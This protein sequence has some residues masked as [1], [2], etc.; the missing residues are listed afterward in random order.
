MRARYKI[1]VIFLTV[2]VFG[3]AMQARAN[4]G[5]SKQTSTAN[6]K[7]DLDPESFM[8]TWRMDDVDVAYPMYEVIVKNKH[9]LRKHPGFF[10]LSLHKGFMPPPLPDDPEHGNRN[11]GGHSVYRRVERTDGQALPV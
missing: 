1:G 2:A 8:R 5:A 11:L 3:L 6:A 10:N 4:S 7:V 9:Q